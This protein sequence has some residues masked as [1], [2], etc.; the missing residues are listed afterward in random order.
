MSCRYIS[1]VFFCSKPLACFGAASRPR[2][3][4]AGPPTVS[5]TRLMI[6]ATCFHGLHVH[7]Q[8]YQYLYGFACRNFAHDPACTTPAA[9]YQTALSEVKLSDEGFTKLPTS[10]TD[11]LHNSVT[12]CVPRTGRE[13]LAVCNVPRATLLL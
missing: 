2:M 9:L 4:R 6:F 11:R 12:I 1:Q 7:G 8:R 5:T 13:P 3:I 10:G